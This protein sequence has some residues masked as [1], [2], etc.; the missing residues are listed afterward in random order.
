MS[1][2]IYAV[3][4]NQNIN[5]IYVAPSREVTRRSFLYNYAC[6]F[7]WA[8][9]YTSICIIKSFAW[10]RYLTHVYVRIRKK[11]KQGKKRAALRVQNYCAWIPWVGFEPRT[12]HSRGKKIGIKPP[13]QIRSTRCDRFTWW[14]KTHVFECQPPNWGWAAYELCYKF[15]ISRCNIN[16]TRYKFNITQYHCNYSDPCYKFNITQYHCNYSDANHHCN[17]S[18]SVSP[19]TV[20]HKTACC[21]YRAFR[22]ETI[23]ASLAVF[24][25]FFVV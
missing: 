9:V 23:W 7:Q 6:T 17:Y 22:E 11:Y 14:R 20:P 5:L 4:S 2:C 24:V 12:S 19:F 15:N 18:K 1:C 25:K 16:I 8:L 3:V 10:R 21:P 13:A